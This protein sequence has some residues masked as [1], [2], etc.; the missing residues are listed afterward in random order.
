MDI[1]NLC[2]II[3]LQPEV[4]TQV[5]R[6]YESINLDDSS[7]VSA[8]LYS[9]RTWDNGYNNLKSILGDDPDGFRMLTCLLSLA[10][11][12]KEEYEHKGIP[13]DIFIATMKIFTRFL[14]E[15]EDGY[16]TYQFKWGWW[17]P[18]QISCNEFRIGELEYETVDNDDGKSISIHIP[19]DAVLNTADLRKSYVDARHFF[20]KYY[21]EYNNVDMY[22]DSW[23]LSPSLKKLLPDTSNILYFQKAFII[24]KVD[25]EFKYYMNWVY[26]RD[27]IRLEDLP[28]NTALQRN[29]KKFLLSGG[30]VGS[31]A[32][33]LIPDPFCC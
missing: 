31:A 28:E 2:R 24:D 20:A 16:G 10:L 26:K 7:P 8:Q 9:R 19:S 1:K 25:Y 27:D 11:N 23:L 21:P 5:L 29:M 15:H 18:R 13:E 30:K 3:E 6:Y 33:K 32:G 22:C 17:V 12:T 4:T 14:K